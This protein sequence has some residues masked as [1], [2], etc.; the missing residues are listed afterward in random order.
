MWQAIP[1]PCDNAQISAW[2]QVLANNEKAK[3]TAIE[4]AEYKRTNYSLMPVQVCPVLPN[5]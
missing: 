5:R 1:S 2:T 4:N 3:V